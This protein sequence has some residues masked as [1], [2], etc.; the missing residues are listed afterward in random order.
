LKPSLTPS[1]FMFELV[2]PQAPKFMKRSNDG[3]KGPG[4]GGRGRPV[5]VKPGE[6]A[7]RV[8]RS[9]SRADMKGDSSLSTSRLATFFNSIVGKTLLS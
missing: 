4:L 7:M 3:G 1:P 2:F 6:V 5:K 9:T 8:T